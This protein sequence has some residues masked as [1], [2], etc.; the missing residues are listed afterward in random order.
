MFWDLLKRFYRV[1]CISNKFPRNGLC[2]GGAFLT[3]SLKKIL[4]L[5]TEVA[6][7]AVIGTIG[8]PPR[9]TEVNGRDNPMTFLRSS[10]TKIEKGRRSRIRGTFHPIEVMVELLQDTDFK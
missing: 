10:G 8:T 1:N 3:Q 9:K 5:V 2:R 4:F 7:I 6:M